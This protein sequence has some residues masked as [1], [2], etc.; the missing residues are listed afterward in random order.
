MEATPIDSV[1]DGSEY[2]INAL[3][4]SSKKI[5]QEMAD[6]FGFVDKL[7][8]RK[9]GNNKIGGTISPTIGDLTNPRHMDFSSNEQMRVTLW[10]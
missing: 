2:H 6:F 9:L 1:A 3:D 4:D 5:V 8:A 7:Q 10:T